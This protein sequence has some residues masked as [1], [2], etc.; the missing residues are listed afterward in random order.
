[1]AIGV[2][3]VLIKL[4][5]K[6]YDILNK[7]YNIS[8]QYRVNWC[9]NIITKKYFPFDFVINDH[10]I[11]IE[12][13]GKQHFIQVSNW[14]SPEEQQERD[15]YKMK[16]ANDNGFSVI[17]ILQLDVWND[18]YDWHTELLHNINYIIENK[19]VQNIYMDKND[20]YKYYKK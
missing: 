7:K 5:K 2:N 15:L 8:T 9:K 20:E 10:N 17:R 18:R 16:C 1:M 6:L 3:T 14:L 13:D 4:K 12:L 19:I 11:I